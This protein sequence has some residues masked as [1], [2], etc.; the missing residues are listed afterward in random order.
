MK[1]IMYSII[2]VLITLSGIIAQEKKTIWDYPV[3]PGYREWAAFTT[4]QQMIDAC[5]I[6]NKVLKALT[7]GDLAEICLNYPLRLDYKAYSDDRFGVSII[8]ENFNGFKE[9]TNRKDGMVELMKIYKN[10]PIATTLPLPVSR[11]YTI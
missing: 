7:T 3:K 1:K 9:L 5:Q 10:F 11:D 6:P 8:I 4:G 2:L